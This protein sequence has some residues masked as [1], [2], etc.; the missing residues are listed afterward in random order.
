MSRLTQNQF[1]DNCPKAAIPADSVESVEGPNF[2]PR[3][4]KFSLW[5]AIVAVACPLVAY[6]VLSTY[7]RYIADDFCSASVLKTHGL[8]KSQP[9]WY[10][11]WSGRFSSTALISLA[12]L[13]G[14]GAVKY[15]PPLTLATWICTTVLAASKITRTLRWQTPWLFAVAIG[16][17]VVYATLRA[18]WELGQVLFWQT[19]ALTY[20][21]GPI[22]LTAAIALLFSGFD[23]AYRTC[24]IFLICAIG[25]ASSETYAAAQIIAFAV[26]IGVSYLR[27]GSRDRSWHIGA[28]AALAGAISGLCTMAMAP[29]NL[30]RAA[31]FPA[32]LSLLSTL[33]VLALTTAPLLLR[34]LL[35]L[36]GTTLLCLC[37]GAMAARS[38]NAKR[39]ASTCYIASATFAGLL[40]V[41]IGSVAPAIYVMGVVPPRSMLIPHFFVMTFLVALGYWTWSLLV[42]ERNVAGLAGRFLFLLLFATLLGGPI[43][44]MFAT[45]RIKAAAEAYAAHFDRRE[46]AIRHAVQS[47]QLRLDIESLPPTGLVRDI[48]VSGADANDW[49]NRCEAEYYGAESLTAH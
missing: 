17:T 48:E 14:E 36:P 25:A 39:T 49:T 43:R 40:A 23:P 44:D 9:Y 12:E 3:Y 13:A 32:H 10:L 1:T 4:L 47:G 19:G 7:T 16:V 20:P 2:F 46:T 45:H 27:N 35:L 29:G 21:P 28:V 31:H 34:P 33:K 11:R 18:N 24:A 5:A 22:A 42:S 15:V 6:A 26:L 38:S 8:L 37:I 41:L 30:A